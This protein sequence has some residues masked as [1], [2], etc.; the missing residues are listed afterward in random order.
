MTAP[1][2]AVDIHHLFRDSD[3]EAMKPNGIDLSSYS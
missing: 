2:F 1:R 3:I